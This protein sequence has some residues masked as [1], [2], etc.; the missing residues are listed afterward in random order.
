[1][2]LKHIVIRRDINTLCELYFTFLNYMHDNKKTFHKKNHSCNVHVLLAIHII[3][4][5]NNKN[6]N[7]N[8]YNNSS[9]HSQVIVTLRLLLLSKLLAT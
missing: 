3:Q 1:M 5:K 6:N 4:H 2:V 7:Q 9:L 8:N